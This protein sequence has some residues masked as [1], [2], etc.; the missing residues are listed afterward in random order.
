[1]GHEVQHG[2]NAAAKHAERTRFIDAI[3]Q[4]AR[5]GGP[6]YDYT[7]PLARYQQAARTDEAKAQIAGWNATLSELQQGSPGANLPEMFKLANRTTGKGTQRI[8]DFLVEDEASGQVTPRPALAF[9]H[10]GR[11]RMTDANI[12]AVAR[13]YFDKSPEQTRIGHH[14]DSDY[15]NYYGADAVTVVIYTHRQLARQADGS[16]PPIQLDMDQLRLREVLLE[17]NGLALPPG[18]TP[19]PTGADTDVRQAYLD[20][21]QDPPVAGH[22]DF[23]RTPEGT[24]HRHQHRPIP[25][26]ERA[27]PESGI[28]QLGTLSTQLD[29]MLVA[30]EAGDARTFHQMTD[31]LAQHPAVQAMQADAAHAL[32]QR[33]QAAEDEMQRFNAPPVHTP[34]APVI[35]LR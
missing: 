3:T 25:S 1:M 17:R 19:L 29:R 31:A 26:A 13:Q 30:L 2:L 24:P 14:G 34:P 35:E 10:D 22:F 11:L 4:I 15:P 7:A 27:G 12:A 23:T 5:S 32:A 33:V 21:G 16:T 8:N 18:S 20:I 9:E 6:A 28:S